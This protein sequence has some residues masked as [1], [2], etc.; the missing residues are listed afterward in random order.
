MFP[1]VS[2]IHGLPLLTTV[3]YVCYLKTALN[4]MFFKKANRVPFNFFNRYIRQNTKHLLV[5]MLCQYTYLTFPRA[6]IPDLLDVCTLAAEIIKWLFVFDAASS[7]HPSAQAPPYSPSGRNM[8]TD[9]THDN[10]L[11]VFC[12]LLAL[13]KF[14]SGL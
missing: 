5:I 9:I 14:K 2:K 11:Q 8:C 1:F 12:F 4:T 7:R 10:S 3:S 13:K 6:Q